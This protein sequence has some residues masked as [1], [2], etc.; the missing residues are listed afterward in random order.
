MISRRLMELSDRLEEHAHGRRLSDLEASTMA[1][2]LD[3]LAERVAALEEAVVPAH[4][5]GQA[6]DNVLAF[7]ARPATGDTPGAA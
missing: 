1:R 7:P 2:V 4:V 5:R 6:K 3:G